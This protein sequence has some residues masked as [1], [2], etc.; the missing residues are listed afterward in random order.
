MTT[1]PVQKEW[2]VSYKQIGLLLIT[3]ILGMASAL[4]TLNSENNAS[5]TF[6][7]TEIIGFV[8][9]VILSGSSIVL[10][11][12]AIVLGR[13]SEKAVIERSDE[14]IRLQNEVFIKTTEA[15]QRIEASTGVTEKRIEDIISGRVGDISH[16]IA[17]LATSDSKKS[18]IKPEE[19]EEKIRESILQTI[20]KDDDDDVVKRKRET[21]RRRREQRDAETRRKYQKFH[22]LTLYAF[23]NREGMQV[24][25]IGHGD[26]AASDD[27]VFDGMFERKGERIGVTTFRPDTPLMFPQMYLHKTLECI[28]KGVVQRSVLILFREADDS[29]RTGELVESLKFVREDLASKLSVH[30]V[31]YDQVERV[32]AKLEI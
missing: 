1:D 3:F 10:A 29:D 20:L 17:A 23:A 4:L 9:S 24:Q 6:S 2:T 14:S 16:E 30:S 25:R 8:L 32:I 21:D 22:D 11:I 27:A 19:L 31:P 18:P 26:I 5:T 7:T 13:S 12:S 15:L 28:A